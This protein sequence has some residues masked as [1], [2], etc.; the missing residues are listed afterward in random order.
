MWFSQE[1]CGSDVHLEQSDLMYGYGHTAGC[2]T[3]EWRCIN[4][5]SFMFCVCVCVCVC[6]G[7]NS[8]SV[9]ICSSPCEIKRIIFGLWPSIL[10]YSKY[11]LR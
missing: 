8:V 11:R 1:L 9:D 5:R 4:C 7:V 10:P 6:V 2:K 3:S